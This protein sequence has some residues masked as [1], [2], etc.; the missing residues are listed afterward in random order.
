MAIVPEGC[1]E[2]EFMLPAACL[3]RTVCRLEGEFELAPRGAHAGLVGHVLAAHV[4]HSVTHAGQLYE[5]KGASVSEA[6]TLDGTGGTL[7]LPY[8]GRPVQ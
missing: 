5:G 1:L 6:M 8:L 3:P 7:G 4:Y 2:L